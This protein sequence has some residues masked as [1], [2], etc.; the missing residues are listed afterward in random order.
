MRAKIPLI[1]LLY[2]FCGVFVGE[3]GVYAAPADS[4]V[5]RAIRLAEGNP[6][7]GILNGSCDPGEDGMCHYMCQEILRVYRSRWDGEGDWLEYVAS[8]W[9]PIGVKNDPHNLNR[10]WLRNVRHFLKKLQS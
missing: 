9:A 4:T 10:N 7:Y 1:L 6:N 5:C 3:V 2:G 8:R